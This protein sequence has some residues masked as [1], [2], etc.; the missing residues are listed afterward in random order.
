MIEFTTS[1]QERDYILEQI[2]RE[3]HQFY[4]VME[5]DR[6]TGTL[7]LALPEQAV[8]IHTG[9]TG[10]QIDALEECLYVGVAFARV[11]ETLG[12]RVKTA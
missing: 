4:E 8:A 7:T 10:E 6:S 9:L 1:P 11:G 12:I 2:S 5:S 3:P